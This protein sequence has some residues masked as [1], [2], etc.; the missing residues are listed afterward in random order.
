MS[1]W[2]RPASVPFPSIWGKFEGIKV[3]DG[4][5]RQYWIQ[6]ITNDLLELAINYMTTGFLH[7]EAFSKNHKSFED[8]VTV[9]DTRKLWKYFSEHK[10]GLICLTKNESGQNEIAAINMNYRSTK[11][12]SVDTSWVKSKKI[13]LFL[14]LMQYIYGMVDLY[15]TLNIDHQMRAFGLFV[16]PKY[17]GEGIGVEMFKSRELLCRAVGIPASSGVFSSLTSQAV[18]KKAGFIE[19][20]D[21]THDELEKVNPNFVAPGM[22]E[23]AKSLKYMYIIYK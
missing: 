12:E 5:K 9:E 23:A 2:K 6:D 21:V 11:N 8:P 10:L 14:V 16:L 1:D 17:R 4:K 7:E 20:V 19:L 15:E 22:R 18:G 3:V 13:R